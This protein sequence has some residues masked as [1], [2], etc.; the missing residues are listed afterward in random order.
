MPLILVEQH[1]FCDEA[2]STFVLQSA[3]LVANNYGF[4]LDG[5][6]LYI[7]AVEQSENQTA[8][9]SS[10]EILFLDSEKLKCLEFW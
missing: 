6:Y 7:D 1:C 10:A 4:V 9:F 5:K 8:I 2:I 3:S